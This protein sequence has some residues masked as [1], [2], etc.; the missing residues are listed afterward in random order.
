MSRFLISSLTVLAGVFCG[1]LI[2]SAPSALAQTSQTATDNRQQSRD[3]LQDPSRLLSQNPAGGGNLVSAVRDLAVADRATL[4]PI[5]NLLANASKEQKTAIGSGLAQAARIVVRSN[6]AYATEI[7]ESIAKTKDQDVV[8]AYAATA[9]DQPIGAGAAGGGAAGGG[10]GGQTSALLT[11]FRGGG[12][13]EAIGGDGV[14]TGQ[15]A[16][17]SSVS[18][19]SGTTGT[20]SFTT[21]S[22]TISNAVSP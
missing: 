19:T 14:N 6:Q 13:L 7:Q 15:F 18:G 21:T 12:G 22:T 2:G 11:G 1:T 9:G 16:I 8:L 3:F 20:S 17:S 5:L 10:S 4:Q